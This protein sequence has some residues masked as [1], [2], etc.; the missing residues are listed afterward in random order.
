M[1]YPVL[2]AIR[3][4]VAMAFSKGPDKG[5]RLVADLSPINSHCELV[6]GPMR[7]PKIEGDNVLATWV[8]VR[9]TAFKITGSASWSGRRMNISRS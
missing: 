1:L 3:A 8:F 2:Q 7:N 4:S 9:W 5:Y 6:P